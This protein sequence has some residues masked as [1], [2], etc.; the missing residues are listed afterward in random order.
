MITTH[1]NF[2]WAH[3]AALLVYPRTLLIFVWVLSQRTTCAGPRDWWTPDI[4]GGVADITQL[5][6]PGIN[7]GSPLPVTLTL[8]LGDNTWILGL[9]DGAVLK[10]V[11]M[12][13]RGARPIP[14]NSNYKWIET[15]YL[16]PYPAY[17][18]VQVTFSKA[19]YDS[20][21]V[22]SA[23]ADVW[24]TRLHAISSPGAPLAPPPHPAQGHNC[25]CCAGLQQKM[26]STVVTSRLAS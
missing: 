17:C 4:A 11:A 3:D 15:K 23:H 24:Y 6:G 21:V 10:M 5:W 20:A 2:C 9:V 25:T 1:H 7:S 19:C 18:A 8:D 22:E 12:I 14:K 26:L 13:I 16:Y